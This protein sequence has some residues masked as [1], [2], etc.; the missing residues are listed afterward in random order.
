MVLD[1]IE[2]DPVF[3]CTGMYIHH[4]EGS[5][6]LY[7]SSLIVADLPVS[8]HFLVSPSKDDP[9][10]SS[11]FYW[12]NLKLYCS[13][14]N[15]SSQFIEPRKSLTATLHFTDTGEDMLLQYQKAGE[16]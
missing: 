10:L 2:E 14:L 16:S 7:S 9:D 12:M 11:D 13:Q 4:S 1:K 6:E 15:I 5:F 3:E 8:L